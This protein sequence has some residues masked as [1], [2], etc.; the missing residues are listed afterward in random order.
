MASPCKPK[1]NTNA[2]GVGQPCELPTQRQRGLTLRRAVGQQ[3][4]LQA[5]V[6]QKSIDAPL[7]RRDPRPQRQSGDLFLLA[8]GL[9]QD[10]VIAESYRRRD[11]PH[12]GQGGQA[13]AQAL[14]APPKYHL[15]H[16]AL[17]NRAASMSRIVRQHHILRPGRAPARVCTS[18]DQKPLQGVN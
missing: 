15:L 9:Y 14:V 8:Q 6:L 13:Q 5:K 4:E 17:A 7:P 18:C 11:G 1:P 3:Q 10:S 16:Q 2:C 12:T